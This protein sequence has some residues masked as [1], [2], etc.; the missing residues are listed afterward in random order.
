MLRSNSKSLGNHAC[1]AAVGRICRKGR[2]LIALIV[3][4]DRVS[5]QALL[6]QRDRATRY[7][8]RNPCQLLH[9]CRNTW[10]NVSTINLS[11]RV[12]RSQLTDV[13]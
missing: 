2:T 8:S 7:I 13:W 6:P 3:H 5:K 9:S 10:Y 1:K 12:K 11:N 4:V